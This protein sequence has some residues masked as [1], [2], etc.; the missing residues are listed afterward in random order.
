[1]ANCK[2]CGAPL[3][4]DSI[5]CGYCNT[6]QNIDLNEINRYTLETPESDRICPRCNI[7]LQTINIHVNGKFLVERC[8]ECMGLFFDPGE[9][10]TLTDQSVSNVFHVDLSRIDELQ[11]LKRHREYPVMYIKCPVCRKMMNRIN[12]G[13]Q[14]GVIID[15]CKAHGTWLDG[16]ELRQILEWIKSGG[17]IMNERRQLE[18][19]RIE[20]QEEKEKLRLLEMMRQTEPTRFLGEEDNTLFG[21]SGWDQL[22]KGISRLF[23]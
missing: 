10:D 16:G 23:K 12:F 13:S 5:V 21:H 2:N 8:T 1:M 7:K 9:L 3:P 17:Q 11:K 14:S 19:E 22:S 20:L 6:R 15:T 18:K 4:P